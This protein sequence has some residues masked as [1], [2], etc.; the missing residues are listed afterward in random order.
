MLKRFIEIGVK[1]ALMHLDDTWAAS[2][3]LDENELSASD[4]DIIYP[5]DCE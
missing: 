1:I 4:V 5:G 3:I 2:K